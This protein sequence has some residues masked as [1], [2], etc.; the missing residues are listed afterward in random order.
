MK[1]ACCAFVS[2]IKDATAASQ[3]GNSKWGLASPSTVRSH[4]D[5]D[6]SCLL[7]PASSS[8]T[9]LCL[10]PPL[11]MSPHVL[12]MLTG[13][14][15]SDAA[16]RKLLCPGSHR[17]TA[18]CDG[19]SVPRFHRIHM[20]D[21]CRKKKKSPKTILNNYCCSL[22]TLWCVC[23]TGVESKAVWVEVVPPLIAA[24]SLLI[25]TE[26]LT[27]GAWHSSSVNTPVPWSKSISLSID[28]AYKYSVSV[29][30]CHFQDDRS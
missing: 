4:N 8:T 29:K 1:I 30:M 28:K 16:R 18:A 3:G 17:S 19:T 23:V 26:D 14:S 11:R 22:D 21:W 25:A 5:L 12:D 10:P 20:S 2:P 15:H 6:F 27:S 13:L 7:P 24:V 9:L